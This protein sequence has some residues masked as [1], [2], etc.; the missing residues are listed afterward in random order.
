VYKHEYE[1]KHEY[2]NKNIYV[3]KYENVK[4]NVQG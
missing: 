4:V 1:N 3:N 2:K